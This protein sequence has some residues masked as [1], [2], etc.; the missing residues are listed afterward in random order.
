MAVRLV[1]RTE[2]DVPAGFRRR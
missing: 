1:D 2:S